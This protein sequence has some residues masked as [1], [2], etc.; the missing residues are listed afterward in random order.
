[1]VLNAED[2]S[3]LRRRQRGMEDI[4]TCMM[5]AQND[6]MRSVT[7]G[8]D[9]DD[10]SVRRVAGATTTATPH[11]ASPRPAPRRPRGSL[12]HR[13]SRGRCRGCRAHTA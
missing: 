1:M 2:L 4:V 10:D 8:R 9:G 6:Y 12:T 13:R 7:E 3:K 11:V 5:R